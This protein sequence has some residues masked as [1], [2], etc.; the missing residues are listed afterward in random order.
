M[1]TIQPVHLSS[2]PAR[3]TVKILRGDQIHPIVTGN[4][5]FKLLPLLDKAD[6]QG[7]K[8]LIS[9]GGRYSNHLHALAWAGREANF[10]TVGLVRGFKEQALTPTLED[11][12]RWGMRLHF[13]DFTS[14]QQRHLDEFWQPWLARYEQA[15]AIPEGGW[16]TE[17]ISGSKRWCQYL[18]RDTDV[19]ICAV[20]SGS[21]L[22]GL[23]AGAAEGV[24][25]I[26]VPVFKDPD[27]Y[28]ELRAKIES[29][30]PANK[31]FSLWIDCAGRGFGKLT[32][33]QQQFKA[34]FEAQSD[35][36]LDP[37]YTTKA[38]HALHCRLQQDPEFARK[39]IVILHTGGL[40]GNRS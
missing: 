1:L 26:G 24:Q 16:S 32:H 4:K 29:Q 39:S 2:W 6:A 34:E 5:L 11:C 8:T 10:K 35:I 25:V 30:L 36:K 3:S 19:V 9:V 7:N 28:S 12:Q 40:Q 20:G 13:I 17:A 33:Q 18:S 14:Y 23:L 22:A 21:T 15:M 31:K 37:V 38:F 27:N